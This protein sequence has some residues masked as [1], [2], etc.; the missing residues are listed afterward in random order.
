MERADL[1]DDLRTAVAQRQLS[2]VYQPV[3]DLDSG[4][5]VKVEA[6]VRWAH[7]VRGP[8]P[9]TTFIPIAEK[10]GLI[11]PLGDFVFTEAVSWLAQARLITPDLVLG[12]NMSPAEVHEESDRHPE[13]V[14]MLAA[15]GVPGDA[16]ILEITEGL[17][18]GQSDV[19]R[20]NLATYREAG[21][22]FA[23]DDFGTGYSSLSYL[24]QLDVDFVKIDRAFVSGLT[25]ESSNRALCEAIVAMSHSLGLAVIAEGIE[26]EGQRSALAGMGCDFGQGYL[27]ARPLPGVDVLSLLAAEAAG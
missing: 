5:T 19:T 1:A 7:P 6:L 24:Q 13:R 18:L 17:L 14:E 3:V 22:Q 21:V 25:S 10:S 2:L 27:F 26:T 23:I 8:I 15:V 9:P 12:F 16:L 4:R 20:A 11:K